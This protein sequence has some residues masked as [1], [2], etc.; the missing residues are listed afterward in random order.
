[1]HRVKNGEDKPKLT[2]QEITGGTQFREGPRS[3]LLPPIRKPS[4]LERKKMAAIAFGWIVKHIMSNFL[5]TF[6]GQDRKQKSGGPIGD[7]IT[8]AMSRHLG[9]EFDELFLDKCMSLEIKVE[10]Y[11]RYADDQNI[12]ARNCGREMK[13]CPLDGR[14]IA[15]TRDQIEQ[16]HDKRDDELMMEELRKVADSIIDMFETETDSPANHPELGYKV[17]ILDLCVCGQRRCG[18][19]P[20]GWMVT[21]STVHV[22][23]MDLASL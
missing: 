15:K 4:D 18:L 2:D 17:P 22:M 14:M 8:Q 13:F 11:D 6:N 20:Q 5:Y 3:K 16:E 21:T 9:N 10:M 23:L 19:L 12:A 7:E 1:M